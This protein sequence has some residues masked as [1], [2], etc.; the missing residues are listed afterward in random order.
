[1]AALDQHLLTLKF[2][3]TDVCEVSGDRRGS[4][5]L[6]TH[7]MR[8]STASLAAFKI[9]VAGGR[10]ALTR[11]Q[12]VRVHAQAHRAARLSPFESGFD[13]NFVQP[14]FLRLRLHLM[15]T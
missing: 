14:L 12:N 10:T 5:H 15:G 8:A 6:R 2:P 1:M 11:L 4:G 7:Q 13:K 3:L 9:A